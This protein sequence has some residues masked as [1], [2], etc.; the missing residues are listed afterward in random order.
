AMYMQGPWAL[1]EIS[2]SNP[3][4]SIGTFPLPMTEDP[5]DLKVRANIDLALWIPEQSDHKQEARALLEF[6]CQPE[7][8]NAYNELA[9]GFGVRSDSPPA[10]DE[11]LVQMQP[12]ID[13]G[14]IYQ[15]VSTAIPRTIPFENYMQSVATGGSVH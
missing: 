12:Y 7:I 10:T 4:A 11:R 3:G 2:K 15:G 6:L 8:Q 13:A 1:P 9:L 14:R 5:A